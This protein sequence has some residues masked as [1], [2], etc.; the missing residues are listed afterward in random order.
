MKAFLSRLKIKLA[1]NLIKYWRI[2]VYNQ[3][4]FH[5]TLSKSHKLILKSKE[6]I[7]YRLIMML[8]KNNGQTADY[9][10]NWKKQ[11]KLLFCPDIT[12]LSY[13]VESTT[14]A[15]IALNGISNSNNGKL[16]FCSHGVFLTQNVLSVLCEFASQSKE[17]YINVL[18]FRRQKYP[19]VESWWKDYALAFKIN[20]III[21][22]DTKKLKKTAKAMLAKGDYVLCAPDFYFYKDDVFNQSKESFARAT[23]IFCDIAEESKADIFYVKCLNKSVYN[24]QESVLI[25]IHGFNSDQVDSLFLKDVQKYPEGWFFSYNNYYSINKWN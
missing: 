6:V 18:L 12:S 21:H 1:Y 11:T 10:N 23:K 2:P 7:S 16:L 9:L 19:H 13:F 25:K 3:A 22:N 14:D 17:Q 24:N 4:L 20:L 5:H 8:D 15:K